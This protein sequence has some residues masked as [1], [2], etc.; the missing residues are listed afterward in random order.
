MSDEQ[1]RNKPATPPEDVEGPDGPPAIGIPVPKQS[2]FYRAL[3]RPRYH[4]QDLINE[5]QQQTGR[6]LITYVAESAPVTGDD[7][8][9]IMDLLHGTPVGTSIDFMLHTTGGDVD[10]ADKIVRI[11]RRRAGEKGELRVVVPDCAKSAGTLIALGSDAIVMSDSSEL[12]PVDPQIYIRDGSGKG[13]WRPAHS[14]VDGYATLILTIDSAESYEEGNNT[15]A[16]QLLLSKCDPAMMD[17]CRQALRRSREMAESLLRRGMLRDGNWSEVGGV[18]TDNNRWL[19]QHGAV[20]D[21]DDAQTMGLKVEYHE[22]DDPLWQ[23]YWR[24]YCEQRLAVS[25]DVPKLFESDYASL[26]FA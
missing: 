26:P 8:V 4:R 13:Y 10:A 15:D 9:P 19:S 17:Q 21:S 7:V 3:N 25:S 2:P 23:A 16:E 20:I 12:G 6:K 5:I 24:L 1:E 22:P 14:Y 11:L 18:I